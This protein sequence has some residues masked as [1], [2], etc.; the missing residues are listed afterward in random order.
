MMYIIFIICIYLVF[1]PYSIRFFNVNPR[2]RE[3]GNS[4]SY[5]N[6]TRKRL[7]IKKKTQ[8]TKNTVFVVFDPS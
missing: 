3:T 5:R 7:G 6:L 4:S 1:I 2:K 8:K